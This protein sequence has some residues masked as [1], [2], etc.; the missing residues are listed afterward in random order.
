MTTPCTAFDNC[1]DAASVLTVADWSREDRD[2][3]DMNEDIKDAK[4]PWV[5]AYNRGDLA[6]VASLYAENATMLPPNM[7][8]VRGREAIQQF[9][10]AYREQF[11]VQGITLEL[12]EVDSDGDLGYHMGRYSMRP[13]GEM[14][15]YLVVF[16]RL[17]GEWKIVCDMF[18]SSLPLTG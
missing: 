14:G 18:S 10:A 3:P 4:K 12:V 16:K 8:E 6:G 13:G 11:G 17:G 7:D 15:M 1:S 5:A 2:G 9:I